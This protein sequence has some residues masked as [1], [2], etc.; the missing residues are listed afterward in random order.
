MVETSWQLLF[1]R[2]ISGKQPINKE[3][4]MQLQLAKIMQELG[5]AFCILP[6]EEFQVE[7]ETAVGNQSIDITSTLGTATV[8]IELKC[9]KHEQNRARDLDM[10]DALKDISR[11]DGFGQYDLKY[12]ICLADRKYYAEYKHSGMASSVSTSNGSHYEAR[13]P[14][15][16]SWAGKWKVGRDKP[17]VLKQD[18]TC[19]WTEQ[20]GWWYWFLP[21]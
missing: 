2:V 17:I 9:F 14:I 12:F 21:R 8:A 5:S 4:S 18:L 6:G 10:Y 19:Q 13:K 1:Q 3:A 16:P 15:V 11:L 20:G 7:L